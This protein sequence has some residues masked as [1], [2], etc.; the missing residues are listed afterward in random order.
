MSPIS[1]DCLGQTNNFP[2]LNCFQP[3]LMSRG[4][5]SVSKMLTHNFKFLSQFVRVMFLTLEKK[6]VS[7]SEQLQLDT[8]LS[9]DH[10]RRNRS[11]DCIVHVFVSGCTGGVIYI[12]CLITKACNRSGR[13]F[14]Y[15][16]V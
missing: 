9:N 2:R 10:K 5:L 4:Q 6:N 13:T 8:V 14:I 11:I 16:M 15:I 3:K 12:S 1:V 7:K